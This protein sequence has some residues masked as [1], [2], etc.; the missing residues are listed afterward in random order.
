[1][2]KLI[3]GIVL[4]LTIFGCGQ[5][6][7]NEDGKPYKYIIDSEQIPV[8]GW[9]KTTEEITFLPNGSIKY[10]DEY[11]GWVILSRYKIK[12]FHCNN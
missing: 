12:E 8:D 9:A 11:E 10:Y 3:I 6:C 7:F 4:L 2:K 1:M 5:V